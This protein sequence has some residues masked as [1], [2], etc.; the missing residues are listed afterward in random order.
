VWI[1][2]AKN[3]DAAQFESMEVAAVHPNRHG[4]AIEVNRPSLALG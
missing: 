2:R 3:F 1:H 4:T